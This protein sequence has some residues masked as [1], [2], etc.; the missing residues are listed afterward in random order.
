MSEHLKISSNNHP[1]IIK[2]CT[3]ITIPYKKQNI[4]KFVLSGVKL[5]MSGNITKQLNYKKVSEPIMNLNQSEV[6][7]YIGVSRN[8]YISLKVLTE[9]AIH[10]M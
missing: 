8:T 7:E 1:V 5:G 3:T 9:Q 10:Y 6:C 2:L 4:A